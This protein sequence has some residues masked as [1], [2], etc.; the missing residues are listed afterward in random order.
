M[1]VVY[2]LKRVRIW[3]LNKTAL[4]LLWEKQRQPTFFKKNL[5]CC[6]I[7]FLN[8]ALTIVPVNFYMLYPVYKYIFLCVHTHLAK[9]GGLSEFPYQNNIYL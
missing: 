9:K 5:T 4:S 1:D 6:Y 3:R 2:A 8:I 7:Q